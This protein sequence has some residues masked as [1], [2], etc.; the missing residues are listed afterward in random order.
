MWACARC[1]ARGAGKGCAVSAWPY[2]TVKP[3]LKHAPVFAMRSESCMLTP[4]RC[5]APLQLRGKGPMS[6]YLAKVGE[7][8]GALRALDMLHC[9]STVHSK[10]TPSSLGNEVLGAGGTGAGGAAG[11][12]PNPHTHAGPLP[13]AAGNQPLLFS[14][15]AE[16]LGPNAGGAAAGAASAR[17]GG[18]DA[19][20]AMGGG[21]N[22]T[23]GELRHLVGTGPLDPLN[24]VSL[25]AALAS[26]HGRIKDL[27]SQQDLYAM[28]GAGGAAGA[29]N[30]QSSAK[31][32]RAQSTP[33][34]IRNF[35]NHQGAGFG[36]QVG[37]HGNSNN[38]GGNKRSS[39][40][41]GHGGIRRGS[42]SPTLAAA[43]AAGVVVGRLSVGDGEPSSDLAI[44]AIG[45][46]MGNLN[47]SSRTIGNS[48]SSS[49]VHPSAATQVHSQEAHHQSSGSGGAVAK[50]GGMPVLN[51]SDTMQGSHH[52]QTN[53][54]SSPGNSA[55]LRQTCNTS[56]SSG[57][58]AAAAALML[59]NYG[60]ERC[61]SLPTACAFAPRLV[62]T[63]RCAACSCSQGIGT[64]S[65]CAC[66]L[67]PHRCDTAH[68]LRLLPVPHPMGGAVHWCHRR[69]HVRQYRW[70]GRGS[71]WAKRTRQ[72]ST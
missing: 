35:A 48:H 69:P 28:E 61:G 66:N 53:P 12:N 5:D 10:R 50:G 41:R 1:V 29:G 43:A 22:S 7:W 9:A 64:I 13:A 58:P 62:G 15:I 21:N 17:V 34:R 52:S 19:D 60:I 2:T 47:V 39:S 57:G 36:A 31:V 68:V 32:Q 59:R 49:Q 27:A 38:S 45:I 25:L 72:S 55:L 3:R 24:S 14:D 26:G 16:L 4:A 33:G 67:P 46:G 37:L 63:V 54:P 11:T 51:R 6:V 44:Q 40:P 71:T 30:N 23:T 56:T 70:A 18:W 8:E 42:T 65:T 20:G